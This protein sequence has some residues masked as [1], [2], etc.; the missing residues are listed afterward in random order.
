MIWTIA[1]CALVKPVCRVTKFAFPIFAVLGLLALVAAWA[2]NVSLGGLYAL[3][4]WACDDLVPVRFFLVDWC[5]GINTAASP[6]PFPAALTTVLP[7]WTPLTPAELFLIQKPDR[8]FCVFGFGDLLGGMAAEQRKYMTDKQRELFA[9]MRR[10]GSVV[11][12]LQKIGRKQARNVERAQ[13]K[14]KGLL[15][16]PLPNCPTPPPPL[17]RFSAVWF[18]SLLD[19]GAPPLSDRYPPSVTLEGLARELSRVLD[20][21]AASRKQFAKYVTA[22]SQEVGDVASSV[23]GWNMALE[24][25]ISDKRHRLSTAR[26]KARPTSSSSWWQRVTKGTADEVHVLLWEDQ[27]MVIRNEIVMWRRRKAKANLLCKTL[28]EGASKTAKLV[29]AVQDEETHVGEVAQGAADLVAEILSRQGSQ[30]SDEVLQR[31]IKTARDLGVNYL[32]SFRLYYSKC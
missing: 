30:A 24:E 23:C 4:V 25:S 8:H 14:I 6:P 27:A 31:W 18:W 2:I 1:H 29:K 10:A 26:R 5:A 9:V 17:A 16:D 13:D 12:R 15:D 7:A 19:R 32:Q 11:G 22:L 20:G 28:T 21:E 3:Y